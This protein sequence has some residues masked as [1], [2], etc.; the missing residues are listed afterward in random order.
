M[1]ILTSILV[2]LIA[3]N[4]SNISMNDLNIDKSHYF[5][6]LEKAQKNQNDYCLSFIEDL[7][8]NNKIEDCSN[9][10]V[11]T[12]G[13]CS[14]YKDWF[15][16]YK[17]NEVINPYF[18]SIE[19]YSFPF[20]LSDL[21]SKTEAELKE[22]PKTSVY[23]FSPKENTNLPTE[24]NV[25]QM[26]YS[27]DMNA[28][29]FKE[30]DCVQTID[31][32]ESNIIL[33]YYDQYE[34]FFSNYDCF[35]RFELSLSNVLCQIY[36]AQIGNLSKINLIGHSK[37][38]ITNLLFTMRHPNL[39][40]NLISLGTP[41]VGSS[42]AEI[43]QC[44]EK[45]QL[46]MENDFEA[47][48]IYDDLLNHSHPTEYSD[49]FNEVC[50]NV[51]SYAIG[52]NMDTTSLISSIYSYF[53]YTEENYNEPLFS[54]LNTNIYDFA[55]MF[56]YI[57]KHYL[58]D[59]D[60][61]MTLLNSCIDSF[62]DYFNMNLD[63]NN[64][65]EEDYNMVVEIGF[66]QAT[67]AFSALKK[68]CEGAATLSDIS[69][70]VADFFGGNE[71]ADKTNKI[72]NTL[73]DFCY[74]IIKI[75]D[76]TKL[77]HIDNKLIIKSDIC[78][79]DDSQIGINSEN[80]QSLYNFDKREIFTVKAFG[81]DSYYDFKHC[82]IPNMP[83]VPHNFEAKNPEAVNKI[84]EYLN[85]HD[86]L[87]TYFS[88]ANVNLS[89]SFRPAIFANDEIEM[90]NDLFTQTTIKPENYGY[91]DYYCYES[92]INYNPSFGRASFA[93]DGTQIST[94]R[95]RT[96]YIQG[97]KIVLSPDRSNAGCAYIEYTFDKPVYAIKVDLSMWSANE[98]LSQNNEVFY[99]TS[100]KTTMDAIKSK[101]LYDL[102]SSDN[103][104]I[105]L[106][107]LIYENIKNK[108]LAIS[109]LLILLPSSMLFNNEELNYYC[110][111]ING[112]MRG[113][114]F[115]LD[116]LTKDRNNPCHFTIYFNKPSNSFG[117]Y[118]AVRNITSE[119]K[120]KGR[121]CI[122]DMTFYA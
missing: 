63:M 50:S 8:R 23:R 32:N 98:N 115:D 101:K 89:K 66:E 36:N 15:P 110:D 88:L 62:N 35:N 12:H 118:A 80:G 81:N 79:D 109:Q 92:E 18:Y 38:G 82:A 74:A 112:L 91:P 96:G 25:S 34:S 93:I 5:V 27:A 73:V 106:K 114:K 20:I 64:L 72:I 68:I 78:V 42:W 41:Y 21:V 31:I 107:N 16:L 40:K 4:G 100:N 11:L 119:S 9:I 53:T 22:K 52:F 99:F 44:W 117:F 30:I 86:G 105:S 51:N 6:D 116:E 33:V 14:S 28:F 113:K 37:G 2:A 71:D 87:N 10:T 67:T 85:D 7:E 39:V 1:S 48:T 103:N 54:N 84:M 29:Y 49:L 122:G 94:S 26:I 83:A 13:L 57:K 95:L 58:L 75:V 60:S 3:V 111:A 43:L 76:P 97:E 24:T 45:L 61:I 77:Q 19:N 90:T 65:T 121:I 17:N 59:D 120:N 69:K 70:A 108:L 102:I 46:Y 104:N 55:S 47:N 56:N